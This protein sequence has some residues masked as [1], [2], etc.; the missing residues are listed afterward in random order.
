MSAGQEK[1][2]DKTHLSLM[3]LVGHSAERWNSVVCKVCKR[4]VFCKQKP[5]SHRRQ[6]D[7]EKKSREKQ[8]KTQF[9]SV[10]PLEEAAA[11][12]QWS[13]S[14]P[15]FWPA[16]G[17]MSHKQLCLPQC[18]AAEKKNSFATRRVCIIGF[19]FSQSWKVRMKS[20]CLCACK[21][22]DGA[23][24]KSSSNSSKVTIS[25]ELKIHGPREEQ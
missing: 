10:L 25:G 2:D 14:G 18:C 8:T 7:G 19:Q 21:G 6:K 16:V 23:M 3:Y 15:N 5:R 1:L 24:A 17:K 4:P 20:L 22:E 9:S 11:V 12:M 13:E